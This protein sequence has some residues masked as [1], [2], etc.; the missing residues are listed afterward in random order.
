[1]IVEFANPSS[2][3][4]STG[5]TTQNT[6]SFVAKPGLQSEDVICQSIRLR[7]SQHLNF[8]AVGLAIVLALSAAT[9]FL[10][11]FCAPGI[12]FWVLRRLGHGDIPRRPW[13]EG[14][15]CRL[16]TTALQR[17]GVGP[18][19]KGADGWDVIPVSIEKGMVFGAERIWA[20]D[21]ETGGSGEAVSRKSVTIP[22]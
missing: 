10:N 6:V 9:I 21:I 12:V 17:N 16:L 18:W 7:S 20:S 1:M 13:V 15:I 11:L 4:F 8:N 5:N 2:F 19:N 3:S 22:P 14:H